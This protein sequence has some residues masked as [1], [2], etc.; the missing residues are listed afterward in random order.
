[1]PYYQVPDPVFDDPETL[2]AWAEK[3]LIAARRAKA[4]KRPSRRAG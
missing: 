1:M 4:A 3:A 2:A